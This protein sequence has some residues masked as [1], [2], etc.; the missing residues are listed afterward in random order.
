MLLV[1]CSAIGCNGSS[2]ATDGATPPADARSMRDAGTPARCGDGLVNGLEIC[3]DPDPTVC[4][5]T[6]DDRPNCGNSVVD[7]GEQ[8]DDGDRESWDGC[9]YQCEFEEAALLSNLNFEFGTSSISCDPDYDGF[10][11]N[12]FHAAF[13]SFGL[14]SLNRILN[15]ASPQQLL[16]VFAGLDPSLSEVPSFRTSFLPGRLAQDAMSYEVSDADLDQHGVPFSSMRSSLSEGFLDAQSEVLTL[17]SSDV[18]LEFRRPTV[19]G[20][21]DFTARG[22][23]ISSGSICGVFAISSL[24]VLNAVTLPHPSLLTS[25]CEGDAPVTLADLLVAG[26]RYGSITVIEGGQPDIDLDG[27]GLEQ[28]ESGITGTDCQPVITACIDGDGTRVEGRGCLHDPRFA[29]GYSTGLQFDAT[30]IQVRGT[31]TP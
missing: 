15:S 5:P 1:V 29:D 3:D 27:D 2:G 20:R 31:Y 13:G 21:L 17:Q 19:G 7:R 30:R 11:D 4:S 8:C 28:F 12:G 9:S 22:G 26:L 6:C 10:I 18:R 23:S 24:V 14:V 25:P 16:L